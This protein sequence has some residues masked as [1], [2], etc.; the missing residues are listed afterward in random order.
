MLYLSHIGLRADAS[1]VERFPNQFVPRFGWA[2]SLVVEYY[3]QAVYEQRAIRADN[4][5]LSVVCNDV[6]GWGPTMV[7][8]LECRWPI[9]FSG[10]LNGES[11][12]D[13]RRFML[14]TMHHAARWAADQ[15]K[16]PTSVF[17]QAYQKVRE[18]GL[19][20]CGLTKVSYPSPDK[21][22]T[23]RIHCDYGIEWIHYSA[24]LCRYRSKKE[25]VKTPLGKMRPRVGGAADDVAGGRW[26]HGKKF[27]LGS[28]WHHDWI[29]DFSEYMD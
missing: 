1:C 7:S 18:R 29:A 15:N 16:W 13:I 12:A 6:A 8:S 21:R 10:F 19:E 27:V 3:S 28:G 5:G 22:F 17:E 25:I 4:W 24:V 14:D 11:D 23:A 20:F 9:D 26:E 2:S